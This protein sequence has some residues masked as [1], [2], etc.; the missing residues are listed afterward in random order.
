MES[1][2]DRLSKPELIERLRLAEKSSRTLRRIA[3]AVILLAYV[4]IFRD[5]ILALL[6]KLGAEV[7]SDG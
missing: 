1:E 6:I 5:E 7:K 3:L 4:F 2:Y